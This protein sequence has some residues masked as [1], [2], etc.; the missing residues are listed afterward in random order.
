M[1]KL[2][3]TQKINITRKF[4]YRLAKRHGYTHPTVV[5]CSQRLDLL[6]N[7]YQNI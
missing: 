4:M 2:I 3:L 1:K 7:R 6:L 5:N